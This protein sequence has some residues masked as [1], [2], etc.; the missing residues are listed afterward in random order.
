MALSIE[1]YIDVR[2]RSR[3]SNEKLKLLFVIIYIIMLWIF[4][5]LF[6]F[7]MCL[8]LFVYSEEKDERIIDCRSSWTKEEL[9]YFL[10]LKFVFAYFF[11]SLMTCIFSFRLI[12]FVHR[13]SIKSRRLSS[14]NNSLNIYKRRATTLVLSIIISFFVLWSPL[15]IFQLY[16]TFNKHGP[17]I[18]IQIFNFI[19]IVFAHTN[20]LLN[21]L[22]YFLLTQ[23]F[24]DYLKKNK[25]FSWKKNSKNS[26][27]F[28]Y[29]RKAMT[30]QDQTITS[31]RQE[32]TILSD[33]NTSII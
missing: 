4:G 27:T 18:Y 2:E 9:S 8:S 23:N 26:R 28:I 32:N 22:F 14:T 13:W 20:G 3:R 10:E 25:Y 19:T 24:R 6:P 1:R 12:L 11:P 29:R 21:P 17:T 7:P 16:D 15:W 5:I 33:E 31:L 30:N